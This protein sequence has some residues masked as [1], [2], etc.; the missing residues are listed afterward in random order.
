ML[1]GMGRGSRQGQH[2]SVALRVAADSALIDA[3][4]VYRYLNGQCHA[5]ALV[6]HERTGW[7][8]VGARS[9]AWSV[10]HVAVRHPSGRLLDVEGLH[11]QAA[12]VERWTRWGEDGLCEMQPSELVG[13]GCGFLRAEL[14]AAEPVA[15]TLLRAHPAT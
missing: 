5:L 1:S 15:D 14:P 2:T 9:G 3:A 10:W 7:P 13:R 4:T 11:T 8:I 12:F 6:I